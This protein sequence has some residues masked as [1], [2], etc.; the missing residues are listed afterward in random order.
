MYEPDDPIL[1]LR[2]DDLDPFRAVLARI[3]CQ[4]IRG[5]DHQPPQGL[6]KWTREASQ[7][8]EASRV[9]PL[10]GAFMLPRDQIN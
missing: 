2:A 5:D 6:V 1:P 4:Y 8:Y 9:L 7:R 3:E 10:S